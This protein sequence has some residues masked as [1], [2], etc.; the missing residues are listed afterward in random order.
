MLAAAW[1]LF[2]LLANL[3]AQT[4]PF[5]AEKLPPT[6]RAD[7]KV[8]FVSLDAAFQAP[9]TN[10]LPCLKILTGNDHVTQPVTIGG[11][12]GVEVAGIKFNTAD[13]QYPVWAAEHAIDILM[14]VYGDE[15]FVD[16]K[17][18]PRY[19]NFLTGTLPEPI[20]VD[21]GAFSAQ[22]VNHRWNWVLFRIPN[23]LRHMDGGRL[24]GTIHPKAKNDPRIG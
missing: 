21:G 12:T 14:Q 6:L 8:H 18:K 23:G 11:H 9:N 1:F 10:W 16:Q 3:S 2:A 17:G 13:E 7:S 15:A 4:G 20:A 19:F 22:I 24:V 5:D